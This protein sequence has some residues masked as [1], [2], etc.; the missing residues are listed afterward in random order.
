MAVRPLPKWP[1]SGSGWRF[2][3]AFSWN[4]S[5]TRPRYPS[6]IVGIVFALQPKTVKTI[7]NKHILVADDDESMLHALERVLTAEG[8]VVTATKWAGDAIEVLL[9]QEKKIDLIIT[10]LRMPLVTGLT[11]VSSVHRIHPTLPVIVLTAFG[12]P[13]IQSECL[14]QGA[15]AFLEKPLD[16]SELLE[17]I[18]GVFESTRVRTANLSSPKD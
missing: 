8:A 11:L 3:R 10:D 5:Q 15:S 17:A 13:V 18:N 7:A 2:P 12:S 6:R 4:S 14:N 1:S 9:R 16:T